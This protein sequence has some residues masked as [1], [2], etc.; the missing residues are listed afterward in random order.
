MHASRTVLLIEEDNALRT[1]LSRL[2][3]EMDFQVIAP[4]QARPGS[5]LVEMAS[6]VDLLVSDV[7]VPDSDSVAL[8]EELLSHRTDLDAVLFSIDDTTFEVRRRFKDSRTRFLQK[9]FT[10]RELHGVTSA[11]GVLA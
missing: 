1:V 10:V 3:E 2:L 11:E 9:P 4:R 5:G 6:A 8:T 7:A